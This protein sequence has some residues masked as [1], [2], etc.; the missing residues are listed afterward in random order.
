[1]RPLAYVIIVAYHAHHMER[2]DRQHG[3]VEDDHDPE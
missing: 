2:L 1:M 3:L